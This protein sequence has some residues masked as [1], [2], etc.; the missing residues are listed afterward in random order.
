MM[1]DRDI[2]YFANNWDADNKTSSHQIAGLLG[3]NNRVLYI[4]SGGLRAPSATSHDIRRIFSK[5]WRFLRGRRKIGN[6]FKNFQVAS[7]LLLPFHSVP[8][9]TALNNLLVYLTV[10]FFMRRMGMKK[11][12]VFFFF[13]HLYYL[14]GRLGESLSVYY[15]IDDYSGLPGVNKTAVNHMDE[16]LAEK[17]DVVFVVC[18]ELIEQK[19]ALNPRVFYSPHGVDIGHF[20]TDR[21]LDLPPEIEEYHRR[22]RIVLFWGLVAEWLD[23]ELIEHALAEH[24]EK[25]FIFIGR[26]AAPLERM[27]KYDNVKFLGPV[28]YARLPSFAKYCD[29]LISPFLV[30]D[31]TKTINPL[32]LREYLATGK[33]VVS[34]AL[35]EAVGQEG[36]IAVARDKEEFSQAIAR[37]IEMDS[38]E[39]V[40]G[41]LEYVRSFTWMNRVEEIG[42]VVESEIARLDGGFRPDGKKPLPAG[43]KEMKERSFL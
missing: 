16:L 6:G 40:K 19:R 7:L 38:E 4:E 28:D 33:P 30:N 13:P 2:V 15:C 8:G 23:Y 1:K 11:P 41:R 17:S 24:P 32:K 27:S 10:R 22:K 37:V 12:V 36:Y 29:V 34:T 42:S 20:D 43:H 26:V 3:L 31:W 9:V 39:D 21:V 25:Q 5:V 14:C 18:R 35:P